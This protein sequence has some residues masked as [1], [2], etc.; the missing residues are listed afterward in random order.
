MPSN[1]SFRPFWLSLPTCNYWLIP[2]EEN[3]SYLNQSSAS[4][5][6]T[7]VTQGLVC[8]SSYEPDLE[9]KFC[10]ASLRL[11]PV[12]KTKGLMGRWRG[13]D[14]RDKKWGWEA[15]YECASCGGYAQ[16]QLQVQSLCSTIETALGPCYCC[17]QKALRN[18]PGRCQLGVPPP[19]VGDHLTTP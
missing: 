1:W 2:G 14:L 8:I 6:L 15:G 17:P 11:G 19:A 7:W 16:R 3:V 12:E 10:C 5:L 9:G 4:S 18:M 13:S